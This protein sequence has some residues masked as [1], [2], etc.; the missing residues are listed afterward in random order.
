MP[1]SSSNK[2]RLR[3][4][5]AG[6]ITKGDIASNVK[7]GIDTGHSFMMAGFAPFVP[8]YSHFHNV[9]YGP[10][11]PQYEDWMSIDFSW[12]LACDALYRMGGESKGADREVKFAIKHKIPVFYQWDNGWTKISEWAIQRTKRLSVINKKGGR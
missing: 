8:H 12:I 5:I 9:V 2:R 1:K 3:I 6:P 10:R 11:Q 4:Y 7:R